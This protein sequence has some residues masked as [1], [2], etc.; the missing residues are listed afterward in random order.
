MTIFDDAENVLEPIVLPDGEAH[1]F[2]RD[3]MCAECLNMGRNSALQ[4]EPA[5]GRMWKFRCQDH[6]YMIETSH[7]HVHMLKEKDYKTRVVLRELR[8][9]EPRRSEAEIIAELGFD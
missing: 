3:R 1:T 6:G 5:P 2:A 9:D 8:P 7:V 4:M